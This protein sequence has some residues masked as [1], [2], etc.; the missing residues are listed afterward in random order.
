MEKP[1]LDSLDSSVN[2][3]FSIGSE[4]VPE[5]VGTQYPLLKTEI[6]TALSQVIEDHTA[7]PAQMVSV[8]LNH[9]F[10]Y[11]RERGKAREYVVPFEESVSTLPSCGILI[12]SPRRKPLLALGSLELETWSRFG[13]LSKWE[14]CKGMSQSYLYLSPLWIWDPID[15]NIWGTWPDLSS[16]KRLHNVLS[17]QSLCKWW[18]QK[19]LRANH[20]LTQPTWVNNFPI[21][22][23]WNTPCDFSSLA[24]RPLHP[25][26]LA[27]CA[28]KGYCPDG[29]LSHS[30]EPLQR[31]DLWRSA[32]DSNGNAFQKGYDRK[33][34]LRSQIS[35]QWPAWTET[36][37]H[38]GRGETCY[39][40]RWVDDIVKLQLGEGKNISFHSFRL[41]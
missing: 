11:W 12:N 26:R 16:L 5:N 40:D 1:C 22:S 33:D 2:A 32:R 23:S 13:L 10:F 24:F 6:L 19:G 20:N 39:L 38:W 35:G 27:I 37:A 29:M 8:F 21:C 17:K 31:R 41:F 7:K 30:H 34:A 25:R 15:L 28:D 9:F 18:F 14:R 3:L 4:S 36:S